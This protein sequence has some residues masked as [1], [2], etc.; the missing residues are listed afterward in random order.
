MFGFYK[1]D[2]PV[3]DYERYDH[4]LHQNDHL[5]PVC[6]ECEQ[7]VLPGEWYAKIGGKYYHEDCVK[8]HEMGDDYD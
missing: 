6:P 8:F 5:Y 3:G 7:H 4:D 2:D 1:T